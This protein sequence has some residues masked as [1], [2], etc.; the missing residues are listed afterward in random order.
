MFLKVNNFIFRWFVSKIK[1]SLFSDQVWRALLQHMPLVEMM[2]NL[3]KMTSL[4]LLD[5]AGKH[6]QAPLVIDRLKNDTLI[7]D[8]RYPALDMIL[9]YYQTRLSF[10]RLI[11]DNTYKSGTDETSGIPGGYRLVSTYDLTHFPKWGGGYSGV[12]FGHLKSEVFRNGGGYSGVNFSHL[13]SEVFQ[14]GGGGIPELIL[15][16]S[17]LKFSK[18]GGGVFRS[19]L[20]SSQI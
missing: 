11:S 7:K 5:T 4:G 2:E 20:W 15:V 8:S 1:C 18:M 3:S 6:S 12:N 19:K 9:K 14:N 16:I 10:T 17:N 13:K